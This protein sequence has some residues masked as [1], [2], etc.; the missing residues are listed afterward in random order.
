MT[1]TRDADYPVEIGELMQA[2]NQCSDGYSI[3]HV[4]Q[5]AANF[6]V[7]AINTQAK[8]HGVGKEEAVVY[9]TAL[10]R[11]LPSYVA[12]QWDRKPNPD[13]VGVTLGKN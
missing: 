11:M 2:F 1:I 7:G 5:A 4:M 3:E 10:G 9:A 8:A 6:M 13:D 12:M